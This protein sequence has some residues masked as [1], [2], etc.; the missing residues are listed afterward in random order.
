MSQT[1]KSELYN[2]LKAAGV[3]LEKP[4]REYTLSLIHI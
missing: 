3:K 2:E 4:Y 1:E